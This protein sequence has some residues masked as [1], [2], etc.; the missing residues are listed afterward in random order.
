[1]KNK[2]Y[3]QILRE[4]SGVYT[5]ANVNTIIPKSPQPLNQWTGNVPHQIE[6]PTRTDNQ[7]AMILPQPL[8]VR[9]GDEPP[10]VR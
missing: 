6:N 4:H 2:N 1:M 9:R 10:Q 5:E 3:P 7:N 8:N